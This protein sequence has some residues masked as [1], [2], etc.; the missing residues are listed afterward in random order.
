MGPPTSEDMTEHPLTALKTD[1]Q[2]PEL[3]QN[4]VITS[5]IS[6]RCLREIDGRGVG[7]RTETAVI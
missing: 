6:Q 3:P 2:T 5:F 1:R 7:N 4:N